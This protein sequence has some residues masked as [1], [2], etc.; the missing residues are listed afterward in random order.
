SRVW[1][2]WNEQDPD[3]SVVI[4][5]HEVPGSG[6]R[7]DGDLGGSGESGAGG[8]EGH[9]SINRQVPGHTEPHDVGRPVLGGGRGTDARNPARDPRELVRPLFLGRRGRNLLR[10]GLRQLPLYRDQDGERVPDGRFP[11][12]GPRDLY[13]L[14]ERPLL[15]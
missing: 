11:H 1:W 14:V 7:H 4:A 9:D 13:L 2:A 6:G 5:L 3:A 15:S 8:K 10:V 12:D